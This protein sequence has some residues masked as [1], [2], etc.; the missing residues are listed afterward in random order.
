[1]RTTI[2]GDP[3]IRPAPRPPPLLQIR[4]VQ[5]SFGTRGTALPC[6]EVGPSITPAGEAEAGCSLRA[7]GLLARAAS[8][9]HA[10]ARFARE[11]FTH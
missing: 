7:R 11:L 3:Q 4:F 6:V 9:P 1:M 5:D 8:R 10:R 2:L